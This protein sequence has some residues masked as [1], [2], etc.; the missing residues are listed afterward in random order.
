MRAVVGALEGEVRKTLPGKINAVASTG[1]V[2]LAAGN[3]RAVS[4]P[5]HP[6]YV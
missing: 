6:A 3:A 2:R 4:N 1:G 5:I